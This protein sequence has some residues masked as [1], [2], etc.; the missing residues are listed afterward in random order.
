MLRLTT[1][2]EF[3]SDTDDKPQLDSPAKATSPRV[4]TSNSNETRY[5]TTETIA[6]LLSDRSHDEASYVGVSYVDVS[7]NDASH[8]NASHNDAS[9]ERTDSKS[10]SPDSRARR[11]STLED[12]H[13]SADR[14][15]YQDPYQT[16]ICSP[17]SALPDTTTD[18]SD[19]RE[20]SFP[21]P[22]LASTELGAGQNCAGDL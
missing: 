21:N 6:V 22:D 14:I 10:A 16:S 1:S 13:L 17:L 5:P 2:L 3:C 20:A 19:R 4:P 15:I 18:Q 12:D 11:D 8:N 9:H 7:Y